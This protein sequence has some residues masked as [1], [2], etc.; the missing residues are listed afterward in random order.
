MKLALLAAASLV[1]LSLGFAGIGI[2]ALPLAVVLR[3]TPAGARPRFREARWVLLLLGFVFAARALSTDGTPLAVAG[4]AAVTRE[5]LREGALASL[6]LAL[7]FMAGAAFIATTRSAEIKAGVA[8]LCRPLPRVPAARVATMLSL[9]ARFMPVILEQAARTT[10]AQ[11]ARAVENRKNPV[12][13]T[14]KF[15]IPLMRRVFETAD[16]LVLA[17]E[18]RCYSEQRTD[19]ELRASARDWVVFAAASALV[20]AAGSL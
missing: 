2:L 14:V 15:G 11:R 7:V 9:V 6:R 3:T 20:A 16:A 4:L 19:P 18:A 10:D 5:G 17:M 13:R 12:Y 1:S 8:W